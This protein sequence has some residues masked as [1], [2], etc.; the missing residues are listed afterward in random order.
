[1]IETLR[2]AIPSYQTSLILL[3]NPEQPLHARKSVTNQM[4]WKRI[5]KDNFIF[6]SNRMSSVCHSNVTRIPCHSYVTRMFSYVIRPS[7]V[8]TRMSSV[9]YSF[10]IRM[11]LVCTRM[12][13]VCHLFVVL[14]WT[15]WKQGLL[16]LKKAIET[17]PKTWYVLSF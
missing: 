4:F 16:W 7:V 10:V 6:L 3:N 8:C 14:P 5:E 2:E 15:I 17:M 1:M 9:M 13:S 11:S 12:S